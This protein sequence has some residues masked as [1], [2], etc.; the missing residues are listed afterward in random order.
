MSALARR[1]EN[2]MSY[3]TRLDWQTFLDRSPC[4]VVSF[5]D[6]SR[7]VRNPLEE[8][9]GQRLTFCKSV[10]GVLAEV[11]YLLCPQ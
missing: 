1:L 2:H 10:P 3:L 11:S 8:L 4:P 9:D 5:D 6:W 7:L